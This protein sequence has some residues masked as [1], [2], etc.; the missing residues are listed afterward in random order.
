MIE[1]LSCSL[2]LGKLNRLLIPVLRRMGIVAAIGLAGCDS[3]YD[4]TI[5]PDSHH[6]FYVAVDDQSCVALVAH[7]RK[8]IHIPLKQ[9][10]TPEIEK[11]P[12]WELVYDY[13]LPPKFRDLYEEEKKKGKFLQLVSPARTKSVREVYSENGIVKLR[14]PGPY[15]EIDERKRNAI[16]GEWVLIVDGH[17]AGRTVCVDPRDIRSRWGPMP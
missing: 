1:G 3:T 9:F 4:G 14:P 12:D 7:N 13:E 6:D 8:P 11:N 16:E 10:V 15:T 2:A 17:L 5:N